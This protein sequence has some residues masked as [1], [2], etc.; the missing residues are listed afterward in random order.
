FEE[1]D[2]TQRRAR[3]LARDDR[4]A[5]VDLDM[6]VEEQKE[7]VADG[8]L[9][10]EHGPGRERLHRGER[11]RAPARPLRQGLEEGHRRQAAVS[12]L[13]TQDPRERRAALVPPPV[14]WNGEQRRGMD[15][16]IAREPCRQARR[17]GRELERVEHPS[18]EVG[19]YDE[20]SFTG[21]CCGR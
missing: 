18:S 21:W 15:T 19:V 10:G 16:E 5:P 20:T 17:T 3:S 6:A 13:A 2:L 1:R 7:L 12:T 11:D 8:A 14:A 9:L 4:S